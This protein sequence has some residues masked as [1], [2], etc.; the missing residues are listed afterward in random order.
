[1]DSETLAKRL[2]VLP[3]EAG[4]QAEVMLGSDHD[5]AYVL[6]RLIGMYQPDSGTEEA[7]AVLDLATD[8]GV[9]RETDGDGQFTVDGQSYEFVGPPS[10]VVE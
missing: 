8:V 6:H 5:P 7:A 1:M 10:E 4:D 9:F 2:N 3:G